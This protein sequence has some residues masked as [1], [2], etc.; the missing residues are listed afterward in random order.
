[1]GTIN[2]ILNNLPN[3]DDSSCSS[4]YSNN[5]QK[6]N[7]GKTTTEKVSQSDEYAQFMNLLERLNEDLD[8]NDQQSSISA[9]NENKVIQNSGINIEIQKNNNQLNQKD[10]ELSFETYCTKQPNVELQQKKMFVKTNDQNCSKDKNSFVLLTDDKPPS[11]TKD[12]LQNWTI[13]EDNSS[14]LRNFAQ[15][16]IYVPDNKDTNGEHGDNLTELES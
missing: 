11:Q 1:M 5:S 15:N 10:T 9:K 3:Y 14:K 8:T 4:S 2:Y 13:V 6:D 7:N 12:L 16:F